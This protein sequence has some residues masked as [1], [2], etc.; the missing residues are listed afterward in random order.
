MPIIKWAFLCDYASVDSAGKAYIIGTFDYIHLSHLPYRWPQVYVALEMQTSGE[1]QFELSA[2]ITSPSG[3]EASK[4]IR[5]P[6]SRS[7]PNRA[8]A[9]S[10]SRSSAR[11]SKMRGVPCRAFPGRDFHPLHSL[12]V[13]LKHG[14]EDPEPHRRLFK[15]N[16][17]DINLNTVN[18][19]FF[20][21][22]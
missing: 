1:E 3:E 12:Y 16:E 11:Y 22:H 6:S 13:Q 8:R 20:K 19:T 9:S 10:P 15:H 7:S 2:Q 14:K 21:E 4:R 17:V 18:C 5:S